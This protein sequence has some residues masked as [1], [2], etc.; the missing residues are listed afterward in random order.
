[1]MADIKTD[2]VLDFYNG[3]DQEFRVYNLGATGTFYRIYSSYVLRHPENSC[4]L[5][6]LR[7]PSITG[8]VIYEKATLTG[9]LYRSSLRPQI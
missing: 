6:L 5:N 2:F 7:T 8:I 9:I 1:M 4:S 3:S